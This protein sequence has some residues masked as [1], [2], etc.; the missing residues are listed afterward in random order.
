MYQVVPK[1]DPIFIAD[2]GNS[3]WF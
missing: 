3:V 1:R 2:H